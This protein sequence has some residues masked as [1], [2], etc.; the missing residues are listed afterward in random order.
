MLD[1]PQIPGRLIGERMKEAR[2]S[3]RRDTDKALG[4]DPRVP[5]SRD[6]YRSDSM[7]APKII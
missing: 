1:R 4:P 6:M 3:N 2:P 7:S 5:I